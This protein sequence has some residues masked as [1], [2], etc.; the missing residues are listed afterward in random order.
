MAEILDRLQAAGAPIELGPVQR[1]GGRDGG[2]A[3][4]NSVYTRDPDNNLLEFMLY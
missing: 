2:H 1:V 3:T 4:G